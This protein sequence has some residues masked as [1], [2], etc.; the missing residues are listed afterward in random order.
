MRKN[1]D[2]WD[3]FFK[4]EDRYREK[5]KHEKNALF[6]VLLKNKEKIKNDP[7]YVVKKS[8]KI[9]QFFKKIRK[10]LLYFLYRLGLYG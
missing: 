3:A 1:N 7:S 2:E 9:L 5:S 8:A 6:D 4:E 10:G